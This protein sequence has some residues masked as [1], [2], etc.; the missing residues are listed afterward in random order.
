MRD[1]HDRDGLI[2]DEIVA[3]ALRLTREKLAHVE[4]ERAQLDREIAG[5]K[6]EER[7]LERLL[8][9]RKGGAQAPAK[10]P[11]SGASP[12][13]TTRSRAMLDA[14]A[15]AE[16]KHPVVQAVI[17]ELAAAGR[18]VHISD[19]MR[20]LRDRNAEIP[21]SGTQANL[22]THLRRD[23]RVVRPS[24]GMYGLAVWGL[25]NMPAT[26]GRRRKKRMRA[27]ASVDQGET[28]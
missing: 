4:R 9:L 2:S 24:R 25:E 17:S 8:L 26:K 27:K 23:A 1:K 15:P 19:L 22:I 14:L 5:M 3:S 7:L 10:A 13:A 11:M 18:P 28:K 12:P 21:G 20:L 16:S 6:E